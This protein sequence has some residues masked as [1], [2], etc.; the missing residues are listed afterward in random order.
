MQQLCYCILYNM[1]TVN[2]QLSYCI[3]CRKSSFMATYSY[4]VLPFNGPRLWPV[5]NGEMINPPIMRRA[6]DRPKK[7]RNRANDEPTSSKVLPRLLTT[8]KCKKCGTLGH[9]SRTC[10]GKTAADRKLPKGSNKARKQ[11]KTK[12]SPTVLTQCSQA[13]QT[14]E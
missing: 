7:K 8:V 6:P 11:R 13:P 1:H 5:S 12:E 4:I 9:N 2:L 10:K 3:L 14:K